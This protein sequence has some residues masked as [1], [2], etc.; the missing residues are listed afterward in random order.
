LH[1]PWSSFVCIE[2]FY[3]ERFVGPIPRLLG[4]V[5]ETSEIK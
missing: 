4:L 1:W 3:F 2:L 5:K